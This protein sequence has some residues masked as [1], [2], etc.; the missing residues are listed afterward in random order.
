MSQPFA[1][2]LRSVEA[3]NQR[4][5]VAVLAAVLLIAVAWAAWFVLATIPVYEISATARL[6]VNDSVSAIQ[7]PVAGRLHKIVATLGQQVAPG[8][9]LFEL[10]A[11]SE[12]LQLKE[13]ET[14]ITAI[15]PQIDRLGAELTSL[16]RSVREAEAAAQAARRAA[17]ARVS[18]AEAEAAQATDEAN[19]ARRLQEQGLLPEAERVRA[20][21]E[22]QRTTAIVEVRK[23]ERDRDWLTH[24]S[25]AADVR[26]R[27]E[28]LQRELVELDGQLR[29]AQAVADGLRHAISLRV[30]RAPVA[31]KIG[32]VADTHAGEFVNPGDRL[33][34]IV[35]AGPIRA[36]AQFSPA[37]AVGRLR[38]GQSG[39]LRLDGFPW[40]QYGSLPVV[41]EEIADEPSA[42]L[43]RVTL[44]VTP[45]P[46]SRLPIRH[47]VPGA[48]IIEVERATPGT[49][50]MRA[51]GQ[52]LGTADRQP[53]ASGGASAP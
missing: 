3:L 38:R 40:T 51:A 15:Q 43:I 52:W 17:A 42:Q 53:A 8:D 48:A 41:I 26:V 46:D 24:R 34:S 37:S 13:Q 14:R 6:E 12:V 25:S 36:V 39:H 21:S 20:V 22:T 30:I 45:P 50:V 1:N 11:D 16:G 4:L 47:G 29:S 5:W 2:T 31:G 23:L 32:Q 49:L 44:R 28:R 35:P 7:S 18:E 10:E 9:V 19:R 27:S 33:A